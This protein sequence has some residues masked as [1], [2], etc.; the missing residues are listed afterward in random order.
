MDGCADYDARWH[1]LEAGTWVLTVYTT[2]EAKGEYSFQLAQPDELQIGG[3]V[4]PGVPSPG[5]GD[6]AAPGELDQY[7]F[8]A[9][10]GEGINLDNLPLANGDCPVQGM[11]WK[12]WRREDGRELFDEPMDDCKD[13]DATGESLEAGPWMLTVYGDGGATGAYSF[14]LTQ[15]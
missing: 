6:I 7:R 10:G 1:P 3:V 15:P 14:Q 9:E 2:G 11:R 5:A 12:L 8:E 13:Y 4:S